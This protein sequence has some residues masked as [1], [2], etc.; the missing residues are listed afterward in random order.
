MVIAEGNGH[1]FCSIILSCLL[2][3]QR[4]R[5]KKSIAVWHCRLYLLQYCSSMDIVISTIE[6]LP[7]YTDLVSMKWYSIHIILT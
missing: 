4:V 7:G 2:Q 3:C 5:A 6:L 1:E